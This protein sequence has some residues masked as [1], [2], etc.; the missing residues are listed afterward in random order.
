[1]ETISLPE[2]R[3]I[4]IGDIISQQFISTTNITSLGVYNIIYMAQEISVPY[5][6]D[7]YQGIE[8]YP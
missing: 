6:D 1:M 2:D 8:L 5:T 3:V 7:T 4:K